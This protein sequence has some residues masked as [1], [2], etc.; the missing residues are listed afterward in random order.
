MLLH[1]LTLKPVLVLFL[2]SWSFTHD[3]PASY[4]AFMDTNA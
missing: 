2:T 3:Q 4:A 1:V